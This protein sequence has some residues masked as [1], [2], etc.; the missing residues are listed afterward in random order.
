M[1]LAV[2]ERVRRPGK[3]VCHFPILGCN[4]AIADCTEGCGCGLQEWAR[5]AERFSQER[6]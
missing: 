2:A 4:N 5:Q 6:G 3:S 1:M